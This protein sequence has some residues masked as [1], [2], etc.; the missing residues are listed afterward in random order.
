MSFTWF[1]GTRYIK[2]KQKQSFISLITLL[3]TLGIAVGVMALIVV[4]AVMTGFESELQNRILG[5]ESHVLVMRYGESVSDIDKTVKAIESVDGV[6]SAVPFIYTQV[7]LRSSH[8]VTG[9]I[10][11]AIDPSRPGP[12][13]FVG[14]QRS[15]NDALADAA[16]DESIGKPP[17]LVI[18]RVTAEKLQVGVGEPIFLISPLGKGAAANQMPTVMRFGVAG[19]FETGMNEYDGQVAFVRLDVAQR[20]LQM[21]GQATGL[22]VRVDDIYHARQVADGIVE[23]IGFP[24]WARD[25]MQMN[26]NLFSMLRLQKTVMFIILILIVLV[27]AFNIASAL[28]MMVMEKTKDIAILKTMG[29]TNR[30]IRRI[31]VL[32]GVLIGCLGT[33]IGGCLGFLLCAILKRY[34]FIKLPGD[35]YFLTTLPVSLNMLDVVTIG[36]CT[37]MICFLATLYPAISASSL[38]PV[39]GIRYG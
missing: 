18:G 3:A 28:I 12:P 38:D 20:L 29:A 25:W 17:G 33:V 39:D 30:H 22:Q 31:F 15:L 37:V 21:P 6:R 27:A 16:P 26:R 13:V 36:I 19:I 24:F 32:K 8:G 5:I 7:M 34:P 14:K 23:R 11:K 2:T 4:I 9:A 35:V 10:L 1:V